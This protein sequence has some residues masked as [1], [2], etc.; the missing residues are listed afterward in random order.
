[1]LALF[2][3]GMLVAVSGCATAID[4][5]EDARIE[6][7]VKARLVAE[8]DANLTQLG[9]TSERA[10]VYLSGSVESSDQKARAEDLAKS[11]SGV[12]RVVNRLAI[13]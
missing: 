12:K 2:T 7:E 13:D 8:K 4:P 6:A 1:V 10:T 9:V 3:A 5:R 11:V